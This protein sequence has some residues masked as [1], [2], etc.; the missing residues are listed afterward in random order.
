MHATLYRFASEY[1]R[2]YCIFF[3]WPT[4]LSKV[5]ASPRGWGEAGAG[6]ERWV[7]G[8]VLQPTGGVGAQ[9]ITVLMT[10]Q[11]LRR[12]VPAESQR[13]GLKPKPEHQTGDFVWRIRD[14]IIFL[15]ISELDCVAYF[16]SSSQI[17]HQD[18][19]W[20]WDR[21]CSNILKLREHFLKALSNGKKQKKM[22][23]KRKFDPRYK[24]K[25]MPAPAQHTDKSVQGQTLNT[26]THVPSAKQNLDFWKR[27]QKP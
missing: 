17:N 27:E 4:Q 1:I 3:E 8:R 21:C 25:I 26:T 24:K 15:T 23:K 7:T 13:I 2:I 16:D 20:R 6:G 14:F 9:P 12:T 18:L 10:S 22:A 11:L 5:E 19:T